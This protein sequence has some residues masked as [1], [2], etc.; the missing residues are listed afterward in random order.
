[1][2]RMRNLFSPLCVLALLLQL[3]TGAL[4]ATYT[5]TLSNGGATAHTFEVYQIFTGDLHVQAGQRILSNIAWGGGVTGAGQTAL[6]DAAAK[7]DTLTTEAAARAFANALVSGGYLTGAVTRTVAAGD[8][9]TVTGLAP[10]YY[11]I[12]DQDNSQSGQGSAYTAYILEVVGDVTAA[13]KLSVPTVEKKVRDINDTADGDITDNPWQD[14]ADHDVG[15]MIPFRITGTLPANYADYDAYTYQF[16]DTM[17]A[18][19]TYQA[20]ARVYV[21]N[22]GVETEITAQ[23]NIAPA[24][25]APGATLTVSIPDLKLLTGVTVTQS[26]RIVVRYTAQLNSSAVTGGAG[27]PNTVTLTYSNDPNPGGSGTGVTPPD[28]VTVFTYQLLIDK[29]DEGSSALSG[30][31]F[32]LYKK[33]HLGAWQTVEAIAAG[34]ATSFTFRGL[35]DGD[36]KLVE[37]ETPAGFNTMEDLEFTITA[38]HDASSADPALTALNGASTSGATVTLSG[39]QQATVSLTTGALSTAIVNK[40][41][42]VLPTTGG[43]GTTIFYIVGGMMALGAAVLLITKKRVSAEE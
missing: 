13:A 8:T 5:L 25:A 12:K 33:D 35:D 2:K 7:A 20:D 38:A 22:G 28:K 9:G 40:A 17:S 23:A 27:N 32:T 18:G 42:A 43:V 15:D 1:M 10:G 29:V 24:I 26:S 39:A 14:S 31:G 37:S 19:L 36:Y 4:A 3:S 21:D 41:G 11:L 30:A 34:A 16:T 6:G